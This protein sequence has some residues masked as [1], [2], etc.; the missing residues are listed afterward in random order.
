MSAQN[1]ATERAYR[2]GQTNIVQVY[3]L[4]MKNS[5]EEKIQELQAQKQDLS[6]IFIENSQ[7][8]ITSMSTEEIISL[9]KQD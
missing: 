5:I 3:K 9:F 8:S 6:N 1:Q 2:I 7:N 4:I